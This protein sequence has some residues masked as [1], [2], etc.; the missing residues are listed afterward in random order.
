MRS[1]RR[2]GEASKFLQPS[3]AHSPHP[4]WTHSGSGVCTPESYPNSTMEQCR[5]ARMADISLWPQLPAARPSFSRLVSASRVPLARQLRLR[6]VVLDTLLRRRSS[7]HSTTKARTYLITGGAGFI[8]SHLTSRLL[9][10]GH[11]VM[12]VDDLS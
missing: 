9:N 2:V 3:G 10:A 11:R 12:S 1:K 4:Y 5:R 8:G 6:Y 7:M